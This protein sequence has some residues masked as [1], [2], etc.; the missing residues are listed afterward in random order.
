MKYYTE[1]TRWPKGD[2]IVN[3]KMSLSSKGGRLTWKRKR[4]SEPQFRY[5]SSG[6][7]ID[8]KTCIG[9]DSTTTV[10]NGKAFDIIQAVLVLST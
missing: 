2:I 9:I 8:R 10:F 6:I 1:V 5:D 4:R 3:D 7:Q